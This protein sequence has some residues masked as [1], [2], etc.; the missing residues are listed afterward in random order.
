MEE[1]SGMFELDTIE[2]ETP[3][4]D[5]VLVKIVATGICH[6]RSAHPATAISKCRVPPF[7][8]TRGRASL[9]GSAARSSTRRQGPCRALVPLVWRGR[10][11]PRGP[12]LL[13]PAR[14]RAEIRWGASRR[15]DD[16]ALRRGAGVRLAAPAILFA[17]YALAPAD[18]AVKVTRDA[19]LEF[20][21][22]SAAASRPEPAPCS[23]S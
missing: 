20:P 19:L 16:D 17:I 10:A 6:T 4:H 11:L 8:V 21:G 15:I 13:L 9:P 22:R 18:D 14:P 12:A 23:T 5:E 1:K 3:R 7:T 2:L